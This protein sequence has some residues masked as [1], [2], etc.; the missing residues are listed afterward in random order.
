V[1]KWKNDYSGTEKNSLFLATLKSD[2][3]EDLKK[4]FYGVLKNFTFRGGQIE[5][6]FGDRKIAFSWRN[7]KVYFED[8]KLAFFGVLK[9]RFLW[10]RKNRVFVVSWKID[11]SEIEKIAFSWRP[12]KVIFHAPIKSSFRG[13]LKKRFFEDEI[14]AFLWRPEKANFLFFWARKIA[15]SSRPQK[16]I[17]GGPKKSP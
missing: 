1:A 2:F 14:I 5:R 12:E 4:R 7:E 8:E 17:F 3:R 9:K 10:F 13:D 11:F 16:V 6:L 15:F